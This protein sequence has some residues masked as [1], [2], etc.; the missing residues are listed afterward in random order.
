MA[1]Q[2]KGETP[3]EFADRCRYLAQRTVTQVENSELQKLYYKQSERMLLASFTS[4]L[5][6]TP[7]RQVRFA[8]PK[9][10]EETPKVAITVD[11]AELQERRDQAF[12]VKTQGPEYRQADRPYVSSKLSDSG[13]Q[14]T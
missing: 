14:R 8:M 5:T 4:G 1:R 7:G 2:K 10:L 9:S 6:R 11:R 3:Q 12:H 13:G